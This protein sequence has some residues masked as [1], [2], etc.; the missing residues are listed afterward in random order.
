MIIIFILWRF[1]FIS[2]GGGQMRENTHHCSNFRPSPVV[3]KGQ[4]KRRQEEEEGADSR[5]NQVLQEGTEPQADPNLTLNKFV[6]KR[7]V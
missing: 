1:V 3:N 5:V 4:H 6:S 2:V 7:M